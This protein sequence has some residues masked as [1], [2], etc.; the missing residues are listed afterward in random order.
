MWR[1]PLATDE[2][3]GGGRGFI[4]LAAQETNSVEY[5]L[6]LCFDMSRQGYIRLRTYEL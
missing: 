3:G 1:K 4:I 5:E 6:E 2:G